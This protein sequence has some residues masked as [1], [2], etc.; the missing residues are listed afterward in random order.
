MNALLTDLYEL[1]MAAS[2]LR[3]DMN[4][5]ATF[6]LFVRRLPQTRGFLVAAGIQSCLDYLESVRF[7]EQELLYLAEVLKFQPRDIEAF[8]RFRFTGDVWAVPEGRIVFANEPLV[9][10]IAPL[11]EAQ[12]I[13]TFLL[14]RITYETTIASKAARCV[15]AADGRDVIDFSFRRTQGIEAGLDVARLS[16]LVGFAGTSNVEA[17]RRYGLN[18]S[19]TMAHSYIESFASEIEAFRA[20]AEDFPG[21]VTFLVDTYHTVAGIKNAIA[22]IEQLDLQGRIGVRIDSGDLTALSKKARTM[23]DRAGLKTARVIVSGSLDEFLIEQLVKGGARI[24]A[25]G[26]GTRMGVSADYPFL[27]TAYKLVEYAGRP[28]MKLSRDKVTEPGRK[29]LFRKKAPFGDV[30]GLFEEPAPRGH[31]PLLQPL[32]L[33]GRRTEERPSIAETRSCFEEDLA[34]LPEPARRIEAPQQPEVKTT[35]RLRQMTRETKARL[36]ARMR[37]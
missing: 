36:A 1:N 2:Y 30:V 3:R 4:G 20:F 23:L 14:N 11:P 27:D 17:A 19:G 33:G 34:V 5:Q 28:V 7:D 16:A 18:A 24:D 32:M 31:E 25:F 8:R 37:D 21:R 9:E 22:V 10:V 12:L 35:Q 29:Q 15:V 6:S 26:V 13:E